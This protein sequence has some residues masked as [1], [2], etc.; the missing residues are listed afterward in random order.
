MGSDAHLVIVGGDDDVLIRAIARIEE[1]ENRWSRFRPDS[2]V[3]ALNARTGRPVTVSADTRLL[4]ARAVEAWRLTGGSFDPTLLDDL[5]RIGYDRSFEQLT[6]PSGDRPG[7]TGLGLAL[8]KRLVEM[9]GGSIEPRSAGEGLGSEFVVRLPV[10]VRSVAAGSDGASA[11]QVSGDGLSS[12][13]GAQSERRVL[14]VDDNRDAVESMTILL[15]LWGH[16]VR[17]AYNWPDALVLAAEFRPD[18]VLLDIGLP[19]MN[20]YEVAERLRYIAQREDKPTGKIADYDA[21]HYEHQMPGGM[22]SNLK[23]QLATLGIAHRLPEVLE[24]AAR[25]RCELGYPIIVSP[26]PN[27]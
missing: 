5:L 1:L 23:S 24:E 22:V 12:S 8:T 18:A 16:E 19:G 3:S 2:E 4:V 10:L 9:H 20:G 27:S 15:E 26:S 13:N 17:I 14:I 21:F 6:L 7:G 11:A 25:V